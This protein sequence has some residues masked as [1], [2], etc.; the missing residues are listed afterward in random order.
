MCV[1]VYTH[2]GL[3]GQGHPPRCLASQWLRRASGSLPRGAP[4][5][6]PRVA[7]AAPG[8]QEASHGGPG[9]PRT[10]P[11]APQ[12]SPTRSKEA[13][14]HQDCDPRRPRQPP[15]GPSCPQDAPRSRRKP[16]QESPKGQISCILRWFLR[17]FREFACPAP[18]LSMRAPDGLQLALRQ[19]GNAPRGPLRSPTKPP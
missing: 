6:V 2:T 18:V 14:L 19:P 5:Q 16:V 7:M 3:R 1:Y 8:L 4:D 13:S 12:T 17:D 9:G 10:A 11:E 15:D